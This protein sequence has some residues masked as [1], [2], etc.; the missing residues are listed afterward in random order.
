MFPIFE[1]S[2]GIVGTV[3]GPKETAGLEFQLHTY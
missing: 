3:I 2:D 1:D